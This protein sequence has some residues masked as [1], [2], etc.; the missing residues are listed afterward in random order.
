[1]SHYSVAVIVNKLDENEVNKMLAPYQEN[2]MEDCPREYLV[3]NSITEEYKLIYEKESR[4]MVL[5]NDD[6][7]VSEYD[8]MFK[9]E[10]GNLCSSITYEVPK[11]YRKV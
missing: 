3:F 6:K 10:E 4:T 8:D 9:K 2:N 11:K 5:I 1:M 7:L